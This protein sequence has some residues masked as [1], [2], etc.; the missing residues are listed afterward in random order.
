[1]TIVISSGMRLTP[2]RLNALAPV[3]VRK[4][5]DQSVSNSTALTS[6]SALSMAVAANSEYDVEV[7]L[8]YEAPTANDIKVA[9]TFP[10]GAAM[11]WG[12]LS[13]V[14]GATGTTGDLQP[15]AF[16]SPSPDAAFNLGGGGAGNQLLALIKGTL[17]VGST[18]G[19]LQ[20]RFAQVT[21]GSGTSAIV[22]AGTTMRLQRIS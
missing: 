21:A 22:K 4:T 5:A 9:F 17:I 15:F 7:K 11:P 12:V 10:T 14:A 1:M 3:I 8:V 16:G 18:A 2:A 20:F 19:A 13:V 6:D